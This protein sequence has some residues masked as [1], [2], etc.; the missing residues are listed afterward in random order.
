MQSL[1]IPMQLPQIYV[2]YQHKAG[3]YSDLYK[4]KGTIPLKTVHFYYK[5]FSSLFPHSVTNQ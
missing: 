5:L 4:S 2:V 3:P 1:Q